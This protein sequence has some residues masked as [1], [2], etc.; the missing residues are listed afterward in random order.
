M[1]YSNEELVEGIRF[2]KKEILNFL[3]R[4]IFRQVRWLIVKNNGSEQ[5]ADDVFQEAMIVIYRKIMQDD[6]RLS[7]SLSTFIYSIAK[8]LWLKELN[9]R[10]KLA[11][12][13]MEELLDICEEENANEELES[14]KMELY[15]KHFNEM[16]QDCK[17]ILNM[18]L[19]E[20]PIPEITSSMGFRSDQY[21]MERKYRCKTKLIKKIINNPMFKILRDEY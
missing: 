15:L 2:H 7:C 10:K 18:H 13:A 12:G 11:F 1:Q 4:D 9:R 8:Y 20:V 21:T 3:Y 17:M 14:L 19:N 16:G 5:D 6:L